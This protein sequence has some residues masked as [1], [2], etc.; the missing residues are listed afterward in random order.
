MTIAIGIVATDGVVVAADTQ[1]TLGTWKLQHGK[2]SAAISLFRDGNRACLISG[3]GPG[4]Q[5]DAVSRELSNQF[6][7]RSL[8]ADGM[9]ARLQETLTAFYTTHVV[10]FALYPRDER[11]DVSLL[12]AYD[13][14]GVSGGPQLLASDK[15]V[16]VEQATYAAV[17]GGAEV[18][19]TLLERLYKLP[20]PD[21]R[22]AALLAAYVMFHV[23]ESIEG[24]GKS[25]DIAA[26]GS[27]QY[28]SLSRADA[29]SLER[30]MREYC[31][32]AEPFAL[33]MV[34]GMASSKEKQ[35]KSKAEAALKRLIRKL[36]LG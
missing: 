23:K 3:A 11:P 32:S 27:G 20:L 8:K 13:A 35:A 2:I 12:M 21:V 33:R 30:A 28:M 10:P 9:K 1:E 16:F 6:R 18:A 34:L 17:G 31:Y 25:T 4:P 14:S 29:A 22:G 36:T 24:C 26:V 15:T 19:Y 5:V 7:D